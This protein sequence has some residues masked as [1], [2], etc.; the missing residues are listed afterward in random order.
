MELKLSL[1]GD[2]LITKRLPYKC[3]QGELELCSFLKRHEC[4]F[5]NLETVI[6]EKNEGYPEAFPGGGY[7]CAEPNCLSDLKR[8]GFNLFNTANNHAMDYSHNGLIANIINLKKNDFVYAGTGMN[9]SE[10]SQPAYLE[11]SSCR[12]ALISV[13]SSFHDSY[14]AGPQNQDVQGRPGVSPL[15]HKAIYEL[16]AEDFS[17][18]QRIVNKIG[19]N[20]YHNI[21]KKEGYL[22]HEDSMKFGVY[23]FREGNN[24]GVHTS[25]DQYDLNRTIS[26][27]KEAKNQ[28]DIVILSIHSHQFAKN[29]KHIPPEFIIEFAHKCIDNGVDIIVCHGPHIL[30]GIEKYNGKLIFYGL[31]NFILQHESMAYLPEEF[32][33]KYGVARAQMSGPSDVLSIRDKGGKI[34]LVTDPEVWESMVVSLYA[35]DKSFDVKL[36]PIKI[37]LNE[38]A[39]KGLPYLT[40]DVSIIKRVQQMSLNLNTSFDI[41]DNQYG[42]LSINR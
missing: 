29:D 18:L 8:F 15:K 38:K 33:W 5:A 36:F 2:V 11:C 35:N 25:P 13:T 28:S 3:Y 4:V 9:L 1:C 31:G 21:A 39:L 14:A 26:H 40:N 34:G 32:Y 23:N 6:L 12:V 17:L 37:Y 19:I 24:V 20:D 42:Y 22:L 16:N 41:V 30:R 10:A 7:A 27:I